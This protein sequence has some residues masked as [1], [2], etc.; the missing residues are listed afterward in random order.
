MT[1]QKWITQNK[2]GI[3]I[4]ALI[5]LVIPLNLN[6]L[7]KVIIGG[8]IGSYIYSLIT[9]TRSKGKNYG[10]FQVLANPWVIG[11]LLTAIAAIIGVSKPNPPTLSEQLAEIPMWVWFIAGFFLLLIIRA[12]R[13]KPRTIIVQEQR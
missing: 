9:S 13:K 1:L 3:A 6:I 7:L 11:G 4:G 2:Q 12:L 5:S 8:L 10:F